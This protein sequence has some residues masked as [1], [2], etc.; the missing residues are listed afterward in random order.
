MTIV[1][2][3]HSDESQDTTGGLGGSWD[4][5]INHVG[6]RV[7]GTRLDYSLQH[8]GREAADASSS[9]FEVLEN[10]GGT[11]S[12]M[13]Y[14]WGSGGAVQIGWWNES[15][16]LQEPG[17]IRVKLTLTNNETYARAS[18]IFELTLLEKPI[19]EKPK[20]KIEY[21]EPFT[22][23]VGRDAYVRVLDGYQPDDYYLEVEY[24]GESCNADVPQGQARGCHFDRTFDDGSTGVVQALRSSSKNAAYVSVHSRFSDGEH[25]REAEVK[26]TYRPTGESTTVTVQLP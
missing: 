10:S 13:G 12:T 9:S 6:S 1:A 22:N 21:G 14:E 24:D 17:T 4:H 25:P 8:T 2:P 18:H 7:S 19:G 15:D 3:E 5:H 20:L 26:V 16:F 11:A 23:T